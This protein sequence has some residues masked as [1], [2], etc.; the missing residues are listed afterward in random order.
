MNKLKRYILLI[1]TIYILITA[2]WPLVDMESFVRISGSKMD[3]ERVKTVSL[4]LLALAAIM[5]FSLVKRRI[6][7]IV[8][9][10]AFV[11]AT[12][13]LSYDLLH[14]L[15]GRISSV[16]LLDGFVQLSFLFAWTISLARLRMTE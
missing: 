12:A 16:Y 14:I 2:L 10:M 3:V 7:H 8:I 13:F 15:T 6:T 5:L 9:V 11:C 4:L 1:Q